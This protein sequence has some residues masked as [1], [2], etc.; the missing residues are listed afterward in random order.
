MCWLFVGSSQVYPQLRCKENS[1]LVETPVRSCRDTR[2][3]LAHTLYTAICLEK[4]GVMEEDLSG[5]HSYQMWQRQWGLHCHA[6][7]VTMLDLT[8]RLL[9]D[10]YVTVGCVPKTGTSNTYIGKQSIHCE[11][12]MHTFIHP[13]QHIICRAQPNYKIQ[14]T[15]AVSL[16]FVLV[17]VQRQ[18]AGHLGLLNF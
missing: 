2:N 12:E 9:S 3:S 11:Q 18:L 17:G 14:R 10:T 6:C 8:D 15:F 4:L 5:H 7:R 16:G 1:H 13:A